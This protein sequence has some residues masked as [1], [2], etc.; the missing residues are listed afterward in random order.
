MDILCKNSYGSL[1]TPE[2]LEKFCMI[3][4]RSRGQQYFYTDPC[5]YLKILYVMNGFPWGLLWLKVVNELN[6]VVFKV[7]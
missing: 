1:Y 3:K 7:D 4:K 2:V 5:N 6:V